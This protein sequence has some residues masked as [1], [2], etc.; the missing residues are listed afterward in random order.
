MT[1]LKAKVEEL[2]EE[3]Q[4]HVEEYPQQA[5]TFICE[6]KD[7]ILAAIQLSNSSIFSDLLDQMHPLDFENLS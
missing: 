7:K 5:K 1:D 4:K 6:T 3:L 2:F